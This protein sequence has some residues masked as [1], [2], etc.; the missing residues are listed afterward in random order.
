MKLRVKTDT[1][2]IK[3]VEKETGHCWELLHSALLPLRRLDKQRT[4]SITQAL[5]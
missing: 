4:L 1:N 2:A 3:L 5:S